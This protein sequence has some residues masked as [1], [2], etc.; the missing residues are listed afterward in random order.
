MSLSWSWSAW[1]LPFSFYVY[2]YMY[3]YMCISVCIRICISA[4]LKHY[5]FNLTWQRKE[6]FS[7]TTKSLEHPL[8]ERER[9]Y[10]MERLERDI[11][12]SCNSLLLRN[13]G[14]CV[15]IFM[16]S[17]RHPLSSSWLPM[18]CSLVTLLIINFESLF[19]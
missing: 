18:R 17:K 15:L 1:F 19:T 6:D 9:D 4:Q 16:S 13:V 8:R 12:S 3:L 7:Q 10:R 14:L 5:H 11:H 2:M